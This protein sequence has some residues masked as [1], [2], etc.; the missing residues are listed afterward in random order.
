[1]PIEPRHLERTREWANDPVLKRLILR[2]S[3]VSVADQQGWYENL[4][5][6]GTREVFAIEDAASGEHV[7][8]TGFYHIDRHH[9]RAEFW[10]LVGDSSRWGSGLGSRALALM[11]DFGFNTLGL[12]KIY[13]NVGAENHRAIALYE[14]FGFKAT[15][16]MPEHYLIENQRVD[17]AHMTLLRSE[18]E[19]Q[20]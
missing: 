3:H 4:L 18:Y 12:H 2:V 5:A 17:V 10:I 16:L 15:G 19:S 20:K 6:D 9:G 11:L 7:G 1:M 14:R 13:L 8:N